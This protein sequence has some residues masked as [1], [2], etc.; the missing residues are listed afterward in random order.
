MIDIN[1]H[2]NKKKIKFIFEDK[3]LSLFNNKIL[4]IVLNN[5]KSDFIFSKEKKD[6]AI[7]IEKVIDDF[8][9]DDE[10]EKNKNI[11]NE[12]I[13]YDDNYKTNN[14]INKFLWYSLI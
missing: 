9:N 1:V 3:L 14:I 10:L 12:T 2:P 13:E 5:T 6:D 7:F 8:K 4:D 11:D